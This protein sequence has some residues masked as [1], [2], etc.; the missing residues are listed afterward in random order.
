MTTALAFEW[1]AITEIAVCVTPLDTEVVYAVVPDANPGISV[2]PLN[3]SDAS[4]A[5]A[6]PARVTVRTSWMPQP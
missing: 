5:S 4:V 2:T 6:D 1:V 3:I